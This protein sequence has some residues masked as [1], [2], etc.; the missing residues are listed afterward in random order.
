MLLRRHLWWW[1]MTGYIEIYDSDGLPVLMVS[2]AAFVIALCVQY[3]NRDFQAI[4][5]QYWG[6]GKSFQARDFFA[7]GKASMLTLIL[8]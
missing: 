5:L 2:T 3:C 7:L 8:S 6:C 4:Y 1:L